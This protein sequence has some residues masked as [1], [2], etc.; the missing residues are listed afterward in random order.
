MKKIKASEIVQLIISQNEE[1]IELDE[2]LYK[3]L[4]KE[5]DLSD[6]EALAQSERILQRVKLL[7]S[8]SIEESKSRGVT[9]KYVFSS[10]D[11]LRLILFSEKFREKEIAEIIV[12]NRDKIYNAIKELTWRQFEYLCELLLKTY[13]VENTKVNRGNK[14]GGIDFFGLYALSNGKNR[15]ESSIKLRIF[16]QAK[17]GEDRVVIADELD[18]F[19]KKIRDFRNGKGYGLTILPQ[20]FRNSPHPIL[21]FFITNGKIQKGGK[22]SAKEDGIVL[23]EGDQISEDLIKSQYWTKWLSM[24]EFNKEKF[25]KY[26][27]ER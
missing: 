6:L 20:E 3:L 8:K 11:D 18:S 10:N 9:P 13:G 1:L 5:Y 25:K 19:I 12:K 16:G 15:L 23:I 17:H 4:I 24:G 27:P 26:F 21:P 14:E 7:I 2:C 22:N